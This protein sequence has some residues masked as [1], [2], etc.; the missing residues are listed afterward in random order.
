MQQ[1]CEVAANRLLRWQRRER[2]GKGGERRDAASAVHDE[3]GAA[4]ARERH[5][6]I[7]WSHGRSPKTHW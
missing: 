3:A 5:H 7:R 2:V 1:T 4:T 6:R